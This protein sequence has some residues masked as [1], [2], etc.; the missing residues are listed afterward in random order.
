MADQAGQQA[1][2]LK[3]HSDQQNL[4]GAV[5]LNVA[6]AFG[7]VW[8]DGL[9]Y[10]LTLLNFPSYIVHTILSYLR[11]RTFESSYQTAT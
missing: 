4:P 11:D 3:G 9:L 2:G 1:T 10:K 8:M 7:T 6:K 5:F